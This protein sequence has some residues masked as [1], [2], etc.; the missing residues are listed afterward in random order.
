LAGF[1]HQREALG[2]PLLDAWL[3]AIGAFKVNNQ[4]C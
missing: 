3:N 1:N 4:C 2:P